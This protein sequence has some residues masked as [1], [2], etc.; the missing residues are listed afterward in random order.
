MSKWLLPKPRGRMLVCTRCKEPMDVLEAAQG[1][2][3]DDEH[4]H[5]DPE[6]YVCGRCLTGTVL[7][8]EEIEA[9]LASA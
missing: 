9:E 2:R 3:T 7:P 6:T 4:R 1:A 8:V 5:L